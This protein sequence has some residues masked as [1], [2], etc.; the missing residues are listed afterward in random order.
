MMQKTLTQEQT[1]AINTFFDTVSKEVNMLQSWQCHYQADDELFLAPNHSFFTGVSVPRCMD[2]I[3]MPVLNIR[4]DMHPITAKN[5][6][7]ARVHVTVRNNTGSAV[8]NWSSK[9]LGQMD[10]PVL[11]NGYPM[12]FAIPMDPS[13]LQRVKPDKTMRF[14]VVLEDQDGNILDDAMGEI[15]FNQRTH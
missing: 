2:K 6:Q 12:C 4:I 3:G 7:N 10:R 14:C 9:T 15:A 5:L 11:G 8:L 1:A 13:V